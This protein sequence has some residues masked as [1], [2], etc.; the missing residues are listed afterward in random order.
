MRAVALAALVGL[1]A[2][3][4]AQPVPEPVK[5]HSPAEDASIVVLVAKTGQPA[6]DL[7]HE[8]AARCWLDGVVRGAQLIVKPGGNIEIVGDR[9]L[10]VAADYIGLKGA[11]SRWRL[12]G[13]SLR[14]PE[15]KLKLVRT[16]DH[17]VKTGDTSCPRL[18]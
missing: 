9:D 17:A 7:I 8:L 11:R 15:Q 5:T 6:R 2:C 18:I 12:T 16:L 10:L 3:Q 13:V 14:N 1:A 4:A